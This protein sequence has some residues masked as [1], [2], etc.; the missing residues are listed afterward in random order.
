MSEKTLE[1]VARLRDEITPM[2]ARVDQAMQKVQFDQQ[3]REKAIAENAGRMTLLLSR[4]MKALG[5]FLAL[6]EG[7]GFVRNLGREA[8]SAAAEIERIEAQ[9]EV[10]IGSASEAAAVVERLRSGPADAILGLDQLADAYLKLEATG[11]SA[12]E[13]VTNKLANLAVL[14][15]RDLNSVTNAYLSGSSKGLRELGV[16]IEKTGDSIVLTSG[17]VRIETAKTDAAMRAGLLELWERRFPDAMAGM[18]TTA[19]AKFA[20]LRDA[21]DDALTEIGQVFL[22]DVIEATEAATVAVEHLGKMFVWLAQTSRGAMTQVYEAMRPS[23]KTIDLQF[24]LNSGD[25]KIFNAILAQQVDGMVAALDAAAAR[26]QDAVPVPR[27]PDG[28]A[29]EDADPSGTLSRLRSSIE[30]RYAVAAERAQAVVDLRNLELEA[31]IRQS[32]AL[33]DVTAAQKRVEAAS[34][35]VLGLEQL[36]LLELQGLEQTHGTNEQER[37][38][39]LSAYSAALDLV[40]ARLA[41]VGRYSEQMGAAIDR[42][43]A[44]LEAQLAAMEKLRR[45]QLDEVIET[46]GSAVE[47]RNAREDLFVA[48][49]KRVGSQ[50]EQVEAQIAAGAGGDVARLRIELGLLQLELAQIDRQSQEMSSPWR[51]MMAGAQDALDQLELTDETMRRF[52]TETVGRVAGAFQ[53]GFVQNAKDALMGVESAGDAAKQVLA[54]VAEAALDATLQLV[55]MKIQTA[56]LDTAF[57]AVGAFI[58]GLIGGIAGGAAG[59]AVGGGGAGGGPGA[60]AGGGGGGGGRM[61]AVLDEMFVAINRA[62]EAI[63]LL[64]LEPKLRPPIDIRELPL[65]EIPS[66]NGGVSSSS[67][68]ASD[69][70]ATK[71]GAEINININALDARSVRDLLLGEKNVVRDIVKEAIDTSPGFRRKIRGD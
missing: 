36:K 41:D 34:K 23:I 66:R 57:D 5:G 21:A 7:V 22:P 55:A 30:D 43:F 59:A 32:A 40:K 25:P 20:M 56:L 4:S 33:D 13:A 60:T 44:P 65:P 11:V 3:Q 17:H 1:V 12:A 51:A 14:F 35:A 58:N 63:A 10:V 27:R 6:K 39:R 54:G 28:G 67:S 42:A 19:D 18:A 71:G 29:G 37:I 15:G 9:L 48:Q 45:A 38:Q 62:V 26:A 52:G 53:S 2:L 61:V 69:P 50:I 49:R 31:L 8:I 68:S 46:G 24:A 64:D 16:S 47:Q 70:P